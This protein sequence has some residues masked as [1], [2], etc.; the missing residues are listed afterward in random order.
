[1]D[2]VLVCMGKL[3]WV[4]LGETIAG[5][6]QGCALICV[7]MCFYLCPQCVPQYYFTATLWALGPRLRSRV[8]RAAT[9]RFPSKL[10]LLIFQLVLYRQK[11]L[12]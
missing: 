1:M 8:S 2:G 9:L 4:W 5:K 11:Y 10:G 6:G 12:L 3:R 7:Y